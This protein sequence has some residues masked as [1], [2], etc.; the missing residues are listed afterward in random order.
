MTTKTHFKSIIL[1][2]FILLFA[3]PQAANALFLDVPKSHRQHIAITELTDLGIIKGYPDNT[4]KPEKIITKAEFATLAFRHAGYKPAEEKF[5]QI[6]F[7]DVSGDVWYAPFVKKGLELDLFKFDESSPYFFPGDPVSRIDA[8]RLI[9]PLEG[10]PT[11]LAS[12]DTGFIFKDINTDTPYSYI[13][14]AAQNSGIYLTTT[15]DP[16]FLPQEPLTRG[17][18]AELLYKARIYNHGRLISSENGVDVTYLSNLNF[19]NSPKFPIFTNVWNKIN[20]EYL[21]RQELDRNELIYGAISGMVSSLDDQYSVFD[22]PQDAQALQDAL[23]GNYEGIGTVLDTFEDNIL[24]I[25]V[26]KDSPA[27]TAGLQTGDVIKKIDEEIIQGLT[28]EEVINKIKGPSE[29]VVTLTVDREGANLTFNITRAKLSLST[30]FL[31][32]QINIPETIGYIS[33]NQFTESTGAEFENV[34]TKILANNPDGLILDLRNNPGG[35]LSSSYEVLDLLIPQG[36]TLAKIRMDQSIIPEFSNGPGNTQGDIPF[37]VLVNKNTASSA[38]IV[39]GALQDHQV[40]KLIGETT[41]GKGTVQEVNLYTDGSL[42]KLSI[43]EWLTPNGQSV[44]KTGLNPDIVIERTE[45]DV[46]GKTDT[47]LEK[48]I[49]EIQ[50]QI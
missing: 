40:A 18:T 50:S 20:N 48:A 23:E 39:A 33:I 34:M 8:T 30:V 35:Y 24:I 10:V 46:L 2:T 7:Q 19:L 47:Q 45:N 16:Y 44:D 43:A 9:L 28:I 21:N 37:I 36:E 22:K 32:G 14:K 4:F 1:T 11:Q 13:I 29:T 17:D 41:Y 31:E 3:L 42:F 6:P 15:D 49:F 25:A 38:E 12:N 26:I 5:Y 27:E